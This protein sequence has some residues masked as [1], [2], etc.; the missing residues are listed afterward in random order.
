MKET[1]DFAREVAAP[2]GFLI[3]DGLRPDH[4]DMTPSKLTDLRGKGAWTPT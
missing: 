4:L 1:V 3:H 2:Q